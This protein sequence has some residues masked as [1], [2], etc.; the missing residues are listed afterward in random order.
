[1]ECRR[2]PRVCCSCSALAAALIVTVFRLC[3]AGETFD[4]FTRSRATALL[5]ASATYHV[6]DRYGIYV[7]GNRVF[8]TNDRDVDVLLV[9][10][11]LAFAE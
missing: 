6:T 5:S 10:G 1:M 8:T 11:A 7:C 3:A 4:P 2:R 9:G